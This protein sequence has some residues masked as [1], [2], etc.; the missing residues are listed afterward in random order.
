MTTCPTCGW[1]VATPED[2]IAGLARYDSTQGGH[3]DRHAGAE[4]SVA[5]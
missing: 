2:V 5:E 4:G 1:P 3:D